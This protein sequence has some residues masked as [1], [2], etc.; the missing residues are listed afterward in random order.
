Y[1]RRY[2]GN[3][4]T[5]FAAL[6]VA[7]SPGLVFISRYFIHET[8]FIFLTFAMA[9]SLTLFIDEWEAGRGA[10]AWMSVI[11]WTCLTPSAV[12]VAGY[13]GGESTT[14]VWSLRIGFFVLDA[15]IVYF[16]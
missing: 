16:I 5:L 13:L 7:L 4:G 12:I 14:A 15:V 9:V 10:V 11:L 2:L 6:F 3:V 8:F 1:L